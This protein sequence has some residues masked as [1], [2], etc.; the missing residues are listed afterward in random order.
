MV[1]LSSSRDVFL[2]LAYEQYLLR[3]GKEGV[4]FLY[5]NDPAVVVGRFQ[6]PWAECRPGRLEERGVVLARRDS[7][8]GAVFHDGGNLNLAWVGRAGER[9]GLAR[10]LVGVLEGMGVRVGVGERG[11]LWLEDGRKVSGAAFRITGGWKLEHHTLL[12]ETDPVCVEEALR[13]VP[14]RFE[15]KGVGSRRAR[16][17]RIGEVAGC[18][19][20]GVRERVAASWGG[21]VRWVG[22]EEMWMACGE[23]VARLSSREWVLGKS[24]GFVWEWGGMRVRVEGGRVVEGVPGMEGE[25]FAPERVMGA[26]G[27]E[28]TEAGGVGFGR[29][30]RFERRDP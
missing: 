25:W 14:G 29:E 2:N 5:V 3:A 11:D 15:G 30:R 26:V 7:G 8:G 28:E 4:L 23:E 6:I 24:P 13:P 21:E 17:G 19:L 10:F 20:V 18:G 12:V 16:V 22:E 1:L 9:G 27:L